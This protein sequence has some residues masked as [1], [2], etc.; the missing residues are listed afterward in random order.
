MSQHDE[1]EAIQQMQNTHSNIKV[2]SAIPM[3]VLMILYFFSYAT[4]VDKGWT[5]LLAFEAITTV[6]FLLTL[7]YLNQFA[8]FFIKRIYNSKMPYRELLKHIDAKNINF[9]PEHLCAYIKSER[10]R[11]AEAQA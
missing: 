4:L 1:M 8:F 2:F 5:G 7:V 10:D 9:K 11:L 6:L 3:G